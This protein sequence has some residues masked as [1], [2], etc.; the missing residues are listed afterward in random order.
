MIKCRAGTPSMAK[1]V[2]VIQVETLRGAGTEDDVARLVTQY[3]SKDGVLLAEN[4]PNYPMVT[5]LK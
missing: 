5:E 3:W 2:Q 4:D 1:L